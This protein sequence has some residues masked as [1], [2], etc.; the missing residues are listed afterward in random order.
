MTGLYYFLLGVFHTCD[1]DRYQAMQDC[2]QNKIGEHALA[3]QQ[4]YD[5]LTL[6]PLRIKFTF[7]LEKGA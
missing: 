2:L 6:T 3:A 7:V 5:K 4:L 1:T